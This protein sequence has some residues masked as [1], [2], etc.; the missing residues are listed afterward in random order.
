MA[1]D[2]GGIVK[3][4]LEK[5]EALAKIAVE[6]GGELY[7]NATQYAKDTLDKQQAMKQVAELKKQIKKLEKQINEEKIEIGSY[8]L[9][10]YNASGRFDDET[11][12]LSCT[13]MSDINRKIEVVNQEIQKIKG[14]STS[15]DLINAITTGTLIA[16]P[17]IVKFANDAGL[18]PEMDTKTKESLLK[19][20]VEAT[21][22]DSATDSASE[23]IKLAEESGLLSNMDTAEKEAL[24][25]SLLEATKT[26]F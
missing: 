1:V 6:K 12:T 7:D 11:I 16:T 21:K 19:G 9:D 23:L 25:N 2:F 14:L 5:G 8:C 20:L 3:S 13:R 17:E 18:L 10:I 15:T 26:N 24:C 22:A 4:T